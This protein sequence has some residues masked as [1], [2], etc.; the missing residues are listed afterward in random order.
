M[1]VTIDPLDKFENVDNYKLFEAC[2][3]IPLFVADAYLEGHDA[4]IVE[5]S[6]THPGPWALVQC[7]HS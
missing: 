6:P 2:G 1:M 7:L 3:L 4:L 5:I